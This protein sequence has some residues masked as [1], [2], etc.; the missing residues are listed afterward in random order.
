M[1]SS[2]RNVGNNAE[3]EKDSIQPSRPSIVRASLAPSTSN[4]SSARNEKAK[5]ALSK[6]R[7]FIENYAEGGS[8]AYW[9]TIFS[10]NGRNRIG[11]GF[12]GTSGSEIVVQGLQPAVIE[13]SRPKTPTRKKRRI[14]IGKLQADWGIDESGEEIQPDKPGKGKGKVTHRQKQGQRQYVGDVSALL[15]Y[16]DASRRRGSSFADRLPVSPPTSPPPMDMDISFPS[17]GQFDPMD[18]SDRDA[19][20][21]DDDEYEQNHWV[22]PTTFESSSPIRPPNGMSAEQVEIAVRRAV[23]AVNVVEP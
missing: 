13:E 3:I 20:G 17:L 4:K 11:S 19:E 9:G 23:D 7:Q 2:A 8:G 6:T 16:R 1:Q 15:R 10:V 22:F 18:L 14:Y 21:E 12:I 5:G